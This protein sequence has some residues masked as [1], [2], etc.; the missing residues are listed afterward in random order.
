MPFITEELWEGMQYQKHAKPLMYD[1][2]PTART[3]QELGAMHICAQTVSY[4]EAKH[5]LITSARTLRADFGVGSTQAIDFVIRAASSDAAEQLT[6]D[7]TSVAALLRAR[8]LKIEQAYEPSAP[9]PSAITPLG[10]I[11]L[12]LGDDVDVERELARLRKQQL[13]THNDLLRITKKL[14]NEQFLSKAPSEVVQ[15]QRSHKRVLAE[16]RE[17]LEGMIAV[18]EGTQG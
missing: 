12:L 18:L 16:K 13:G 17:K 5:K 11:Y 3:E 10:T 9:T 8:S 14:N 4:V 1:Q 2:L 7:Q 15:Q 6:A